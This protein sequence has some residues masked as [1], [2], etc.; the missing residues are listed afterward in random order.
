MIYAWV[1]TVI[2]L[3][4]PVSISS[5]LSDIWL[6]LELNKHYF[7]TANGTLVFCA[8]HWGSSVIEHWGCIICLKQIGL[9]GPCTWWGSTCGSELPGPG[10]FL[11][12]V[13]VGEICGVGPLFVAFRLQRPEECLICC[14]GT[15]QVNEIFVAL[16]MHMGEDLE[17][18]V[19]HPKRCGFE[20][21]ATTNILPVLFATELGVLVTV[22]VKYTALGYF[23]NMQ[24]MASKTGWIRWSNFSLIYDL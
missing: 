6:R 10:N 9:F 8:E 4:R 23:S 19:G 14:C 20:Q 3:N 18:L 1:P 13:Q 15:T 21:K 17:Q 7:V 12:Y 11:N 24:G 22:S 16:L 5:V 2:N